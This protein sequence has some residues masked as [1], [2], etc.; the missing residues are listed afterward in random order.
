MKPRGLALVVLA[1]LVVTTLFA[2]VATAQSGPQG[3]QSSDLSTPID[4][5][6]SSPTQIDAHYDTGNKITTYMPGQSNT[7]SPQQTAN[8]KG[9]QPRERPARNKDNATPTEATP[10][11]GNSA[12]PGGS[13]GSSGGSSGPIIS[14]GSPLTELPKT[15]GPALN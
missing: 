10:S 15:G 7:N 9:K 8:P 4:V 3:T 1:G 14:S 2:A 12:N 5:A 13:G 6:G 11:A